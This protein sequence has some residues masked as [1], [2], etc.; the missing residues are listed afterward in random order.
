MP[1]NPDTWL[2]LALPSWT[3]LPITVAI[4]RQSVLWPWPHKDP[5]GRLLAATAQ[6]EGLEFWHTDTVLKDL[7][8]FPHRYFANVEPGKRKQ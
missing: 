1:D 8:G 4:A 2:D 7:T 5:A 3:A 6:V